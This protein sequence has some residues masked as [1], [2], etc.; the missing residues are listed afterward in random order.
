MII[1]LFIR[2]NSLFFPL[3]RWHKLFCKLNSPIYI[4]PNIPIRASCFCAAIPFPS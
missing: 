4:I 3:P 1:S 2:E